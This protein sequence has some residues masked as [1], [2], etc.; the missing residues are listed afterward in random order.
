MNATRQ[1]GRYLAGN[2]IGRGGMGEVYLA[3]DPSMD[4]QVA[5]KLLKPE[6]AEGLGLELFKKEMKHHGRL[7]HT[8]IITALDMGETENGRLYMVM[9]YFKGETL[10]RRLQ[11]EAVLA[12]EVVIS[13]LEQL[14]AA[15]EHAHG[16]NVLHGDLKP[17]NILIDARGRV[18]ILDFGVARA[19]HTMGKTDQRP[20]MGTPEYSSPEQ[21]NREILDRRSDLYSLAVLA[22]ELLSGERPRLEPDTRDLKPNP[23]AKPSQTLP[24]RN[25]GHFAFFFRA[26]HPRRDKRP[27]TAKRFCDELVGLLKEQGW[28]D[29]FCFEYRDI[30]WP[31]EVEEPEPIRPAKG[32]PTEPKISGIRKQ[33][34]P[35]VLAGAPVLST[36][37]Y[38]TGLQAHRAR[39][40]ILD[41]GPLDYAETYLIYE[42]F[43]AF[44]SLL[45]SGLVALG[46]R[47][48]VLQICA[49]VL[50][51]LTLLAGAA[52][53]YAKRL[54]KTVMVLLLVVGLVLFRGAD[55]YQAAVY[56]ANPGQ[57]FSEQANAWTVPRRTGNRIDD[58]AFETH[59]WLTNPDPVHD[60]DRWDVAGLLFWF[61]AA[62]A[63]A[64]TA[65]YRM[66]PE[67]R[68]LWVRH[69]LSAGFVVLFMILIQKLPRAYAFANWGLTYR[70]ASID[71]T[72]L[73]QLPQDK[74]IAEGLKQG[75][76]RIFDISEGGSPPTF[77][78]QGGSF[79]QG[80]SLQLSPKSVGGLSKGPRV[81]IPTVSDQKEAHLD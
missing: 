39:E 28:P 35:I 15:L 50:F 36:L 44:S 66:R 1:F 20:Y 59:S 10:R 7:N 19:I 68:T 40:A 34:L 3:R 74:M 42:G 23:P 41:F 63:L 79:G 55:Y 76:L 70:V 26:L 13:V 73:Q 46:A 2:E 8:N 4:R 16:Q 12:P 80:E 38:F 62:N 31:E 43:L 75:A 6:L 9:E 45:S 71:E 22:H 57:P 32:K 60:Q 48:T 11:R 5:L 17:G 24:A 67:G 37:L 33:W 77:W 51:L 78:I 61:L 81:V 58:I 21:L 72:F 27:R 49:L 65:L 25:A 53:A 30:K 64:I 47:V 52:C 29:D 54:P 14:G 18:K 56:A 69:A